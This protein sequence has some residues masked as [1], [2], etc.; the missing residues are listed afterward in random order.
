MRRLTLTVALTTALLLAFSGPVAAVQFGTPDSNNRYSEVGLMV[1]KVTNQ[2]GNLVPAWRC[3][4][5]LLSST[6]F[7]T[8]GHCVSG[9]D[10]VEVWFDWNVI[11]DPAYPSSTAGDPCAG[12]GGYPCTGDTS[13][14][15]IPHPEYD[16]F[17]Q[18]PATYDI[19][20]VILDDAQTGHTYA[21]LPQV[22]VLDGMARTSRKGT[23]FDLAGYGVQ[24][25][26]RPF[27]RATL[28]RHYGHASII[29]TRSAN[30]AGYSV[31][32]SAAPGKGGALCF[33]DSGGPVYLTGTRTVVAV[34]SFVFNYQCMGSGFSYR[35]DTTDSLNFI[36]A[37]S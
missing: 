1:A 35:V 32:L 25:T 30:T 10:E 34:N 11:R 4:G 23:Q 3:T 13:G 9:A 17:A 37:N 27:Y 22:G 8:A 31:Q 5:A 15:P 18:Y 2:A 6:V 20:L 28:T 14:T 36:A 29:N 24:D 19:G 12:I 16:D 33:G 26:R 7:L 21:Q